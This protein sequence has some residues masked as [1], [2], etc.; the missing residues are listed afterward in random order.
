MQVELPVRLHYLLRDPLLPEGVERIA[1]LVVS[2][3]GD[4]QQESLICDI[5]VLGG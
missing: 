4:L 2:L 3:H 1:D 5:T